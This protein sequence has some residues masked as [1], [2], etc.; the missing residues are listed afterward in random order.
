M[1]F[2][3]FKNNLYIMYII[4]SPKSCDPISLQAFSA[5]KIKDGEKV[6]KQTK[7]VGNTEGLQKKQMGN[8]NRSP[9]HFPKP[10]CSPCLWKFVVCPFVDKEK[11]GSYSTENFSYYTE[12]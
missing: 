6:K 5:W 7:I 3:T 9:G 1:K 12:M 11:N 10:V 8:R 4:L 2:K